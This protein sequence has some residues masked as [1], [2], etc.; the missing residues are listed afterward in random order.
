MQISE[1]ELE[2]YIYNDIRNQDAMNI[3][4][5]GLNL[6]VTTLPV[7]SYW[8]RQ[9][10]IDPY[11]IIDLIGYCKFQGELYIDLVELKVTE[12]KL[13]HFEQIFRYKSGV[14]R[15]LKSKIS[16]VNINCYLIVKDEVEEGIYIQNE[17]NI[18]VATYSYSISGIDFDMTRPFPGWYKTSDINVSIKDLQLNGK[19]I[20]CNGEVG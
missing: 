17:S 4:A 1:K 20:H 10:N 8:I 13:D 6:I 16:R 15:Y 12:S 7:K 18:H 3:Q 19:A 5:R 14:R 11:G 2:D 9:L